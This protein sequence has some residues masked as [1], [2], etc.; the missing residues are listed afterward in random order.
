MIVEFLEGR[1]FM[2]AWVLFPATH[3]LGVL[4]LN[5]R[6]M[7][8]SQN[9]VLNSA[10]LPDPGSRPTRLE[11]LRATDAARRGLAAE[12]DLAEL[13]SVLA[14]EGPEFSFETLATLFF[15]RTARADEVSAMARAVFTDGLRFRFAPGG[16]LRHDSEEVERLL[17]ARRRAAE[18]ESALAAAAEWLAALKRGAPAPEPPA[19]APAK[20]ALLNLALGD[21]NRSGQ[22]E[23]KKILARA[24]FAPEAEGAVEALRLAGEFGPHENLELRRLDFPT[25]FPPELTDEARRAAAGAGRPAA[26]REKRLDLTGLTTL[27]IDSNGA[28]D[29]DDAVS[30]KSLAGGRWQV[31]LHITD[32]AA[33]IPPDSPLD[34][35]G[36]ARSTSVYLPDGKYPML[37]PELSEGFLSLTPGDVKPS[38][39]F[40]ATLE[41]DGAVA[42]YAL[43]LSLIR[44]DRQLSF[45]EADAGL[46]EDSDLVDLWDLAQALLARRLTR[47]GVNLNIPKLNIYFLPDGALSVGLTQWDTPAKLIVGELMILA[48]HLAADLLHK[49]GYPCPFR[50]QEKP[51]APIPAELTAASAAGGATSD[52]LLALAL[53]ARRRTGRGGL[54]F[55]PSPH[56]GLGLPVYTAFTAPM[57]RYLDLLVARQLRS[58]VLGRPPAFDEPAFLRLALPAH[59]YTLRLHKMQAGRIRYWLKQYLRDKTGREYSA[60][61]FEQRDRRLRI[62]LTDY[63][64]ETEAFWPKGAGGCPPDL[65]GRRLPVRLA[66]VPAGEAPPRYEVIA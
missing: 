56:H 54:S 64:L 7:S 5:G 34:L 26:D 62:C 9:R 51:R 65:T 19:A 55:V 43:Y 31:G 63:M 66:E 6:E 4:A 21:E 29:L 59:D 46:N 44:V 32:V 35:A 12:V 61:V 38:F 50:Y 41:K 39:S 60:L 3:R 52:R 36:R 15:G 13:W 58:L 33:V 28:R 22:A 17:A 20:A 14:D 37:P 25:A 48:N 23:A 45:A 40:L 42:D 27:T 16:A 11:L 57:R 2:T 47:G 53:A 1:D 24:G 8:I 30:V 10:E 18:E 49:N